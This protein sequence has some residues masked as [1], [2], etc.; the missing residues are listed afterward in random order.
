MRRLAIALGVLAILALVVGGCSDS[1]A[2][3]TLVDYGEQPVI[4]QDASLPN[5]PPAQ[6]VNYFS[7]LEHLQPARQALR[8]PTG[9][10]KIFL[11]D[12]QFLIQANSNDVWCLDAKTLVVEWKWMGIVGELS[13]DP[14]WNPFTFYVVAR[15]RMYALSRQTGEERWRFD[16][17]FSPSCAPVAHDYYILMGS[18]DGRV[19]CCVDDITTARVAW[20]HSI[21][22]PVRSTPMVANIVDNTW[23]HVVADNGSYSKYLPNRTKNVPHRSQVTIGA[24]CRGPMAHDSKLA[25]IAS[26]D[27]NVYAFH[28]IE[29]VRWVVRTEDECN[30]GAFLQ[31]GTLFVRNSKQMIALKA[32]NG[33]TMWV[34]KSLDRFLVKLKRYHYFVSTDGRLVGLSNKDWQKMWSIDLKPFDFQFYSE[35]LPYLYVATKDGY[36]MSYEEKF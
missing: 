22:A 35:T 18:W 30:R 15:D 10:K 20:Y 5:E 29:G 14:A 25:Y 34:D 8:I 26:L 27:Y 28:P 19:Y 4:Q 13:Y 16:L 2:K 1:A 21:G 32:E 24:G 36:I 31:D 33:D 3:H 17:P 23:F 7:S 12:D 6:L 11:C 9:I